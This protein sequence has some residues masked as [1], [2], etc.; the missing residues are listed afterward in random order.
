MN[1]IQIDQGTQVTNLLRN[2]FLHLEESVVV[3]LSQVFSTEV[4]NANLFIVSTAGTWFLVQGTKPIL[5][6]GGMHKIPRNCVWHFITLANF[7]S[8]LCCPKA[9][10]ATTHRKAG[11]QLCRL[12][13]GHLLCSISEFQS[14]L[15]IK[16]TK[17][18]TKLNLEGNELISTQGPANFAVYPHSE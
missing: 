16:N 18:R 9:T 10:P 14:S 5:Q 12:I 6:K 7:I 4:I 17:K 3:G 15:S 11:I 1:G 13:M 2:P 8:F